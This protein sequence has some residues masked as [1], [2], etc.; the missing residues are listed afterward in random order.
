MPLVWTNHPGRSI[1]DAGGRREHH[2]R[3][4]RVEVVGSGLDHRIA[5]GARP[6][7][8][9]AQ[10]GGDPLQRLDRVVQAGGLVAP[11]GVE[12]RLRGADPDQALERPPVDAGRAAQ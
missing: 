11:G 8:S 12:A 7:R 1:A 2:R 4:A 10:R 5:Q 3:P 6:V 9:G